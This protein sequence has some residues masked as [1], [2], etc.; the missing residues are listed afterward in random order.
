MEGRGE[1]IPRRTV[2]RRGGGGQVI[3]ID[4]RSG[5]WPRPFGRRSYVHRDHA[6]CDY[7][8]CIFVSVAGKYSRRSGSPAL[9]TSPMQSSEPR[10]YFATPSYP[11]SLPPIISTRYFQFYVGFVPRHILDFIITVSTN[12]CTNCFIS[13]WKKGRYEGRVSFRG[14]NKW[15]YF[16]IVFIRKILIVRFLSSYIWFYR[17]IIFNNFSYER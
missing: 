2:H 16:D 1:W 9:S 15:R 17:S 11:P 3:V 13:R 5:G 7:P 10:K 14:I 8:P 12:N 6:P 4:W